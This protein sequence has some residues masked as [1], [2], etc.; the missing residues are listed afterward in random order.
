MS[1]KNAIIILIIMAVC[2]ALFFVYLYYDNKLIISP[3]NKLDS[4]LA[5]QAD[6]DAVKQ[7]KEP[8]QLT[9]EEKKQ[10]LL[11][12]MAEVE[13][14]NPSADPENESEQTQEE[15]MQELLQAMAEAAEINP[16]ED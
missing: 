10:E 11:Q 1:V 13:K 4:S 2:G 5:D 7:D 15:K 8:E 14:I 16:S 9:Q 12:A 6:K 3:A